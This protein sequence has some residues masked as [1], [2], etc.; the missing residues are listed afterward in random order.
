MS[1]G[2]NWA[3]SSCVLILLLAGCA[4]APIDAP[5]PPASESEIIA[6]T[7]NVPE[8]IP[9]PESAPEPAPV[10]DRSSERITIAAVG[11]MMLGT[12]YP[13][14]HLPDDDG[15]SF[16]ADVSEVL[17]SADITFGNLEGVLVDGGEPGK[18]AATRTPAT[19]FVRRHVTCSIIRTPVLTW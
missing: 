12:D 7:A 16:L 8:A 19:C 15:V 6:E 11:D 10:P 2:S 5:E 14:N 4:S 9:E 3:T 18:N 1:S 13:E 17:S